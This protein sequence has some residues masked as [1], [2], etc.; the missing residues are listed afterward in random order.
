MKRN[1]DVTLIDTMGNDLTVVNAARVSMAKHSR[2]VTEKDIALLKYLAVNKHWTPFGH[3]ILQFHFNMPIFVIR[4]WYR[5]TV[6]LLRNEESRRYIDSRP[7][8][9]M[10]SHW[11]KQSRRIKQGS[12]SVSVKDESLVTISVRDCYAEL[13][14]RYSFLIGRGV[15]REQA[16]MILPQ[17]M[18][19]QFIETGSLY[20]YA[21]ICKLRLDPHAQKEI[22]DYAEQVAKFCKQTA[23]LAWKALMETSIE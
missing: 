15:C 17:A 2:K 13:E 19:T 10:P 7:T 18:M 8:F 5:H 9:F 6:G 22:H 3:V 12:S 4:Q 11:R 23:P 14:R 21:R 20:A 1:N 16:R